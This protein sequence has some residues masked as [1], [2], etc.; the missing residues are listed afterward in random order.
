MKVA[1]YLRVSTSDQSCDLQ[2]AELKT[3][4]RIRGWSNLEVFSDKATGTNTDRPEF[5]RMMKLVRN[6]SI[7]LVLVWKL[8]RMARSTRDLVNVLHEL[9][10]LDVQFVA[11][12]DNID[13]T[14][15]SGKLLCHL[16]GAFAEFEA[17]LIKERVRAGLARAKER[18]VRLGRPRKS[19][20]DHVKIRELRK[21]GTGPT[22]IARDLGICR[23]TVYRILKAA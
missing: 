6:G 15:A 18:G 12:K 3:H 19:K 11:L 5:Q 8:D 22:Q 13:L 7:G 1:A 20:I 23:A 9:T 4:A 10:E 17:S 2:E 21:S 16:I 14:T